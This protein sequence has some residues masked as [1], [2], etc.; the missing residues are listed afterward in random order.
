MWLTSL[1]DPFMSINV[2]Q[3]KVMGTYFARNTTHTGKANWTLLDKKYIKSLQ[4]SIA[5]SHFCRAK[6]VGGLHSPQQSSTTAIEAHSKRCNLQLGS[7]HLLN[8]FLSIIFGFWARFLI[9][10]SNFVTMKLSIWA[11]KRAQ[12][13]FEQILFWSE[14]S[15]RIVYRITVYP[16]RNNLN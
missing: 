12:T 13:Q 6:S 11:K 14:P 2:A 8:F 5:I 15:Y 1:F 7:L 16:F 4:I 10:C 9:I 3:P